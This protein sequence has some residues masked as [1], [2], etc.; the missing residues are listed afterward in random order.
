MSKDDR[1][2]PDLDAMQP[3]DEL[4]LADRD[5][6]QQVEALRDAAVPDPGP[7]YWAAFQGRLQERLAA[8]PPARRWIPW[9]GMAV[10]AT[11]VMLMWMGGR[12]L[13]HH[14]DTVLP[15][16]A[17]LTALDMLNAWEGDHLDGALDLILGERPTGVLAGDLQDL[18]LDE[19]QALLENLR[20]ELS[21]SAAPVPAGQ[22]P[23]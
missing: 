15:G 11:L 14:P 22:G 13:E 21:R 23:A 6:L 12:V 1:K 4:N 19:K 16:E 20:D 2:K 18:T 10:A 3:Q 5:A 17:A 8:G 9:A 7:L